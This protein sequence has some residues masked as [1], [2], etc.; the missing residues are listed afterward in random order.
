MSQG[1]K[2]LGCKEFL[3]LCG[4]TKNTL[5]WYEKKGLI[6]PK[7]VGENGYRYY[8]KEQFYE[9]DLIKSLKWVDKSLDDCKSYM[10]HRSEETYLPMLLE[11]QRTLEQ[12]IVAL[13]N[14][15]R[16]VDQT[17]QDYLSMK[18]RYSQ[19]PRFLTLPESYL[20]VEP[21]DDVTP[22]GYMMTLNRL[23]ETFHDCLP[24]YHA[25]PSM[26]NCSI[27]SHQDLLSENFHQLSYA[28]L[29]ISMQI[30]IAACRTIPKGT[31]AVCSHR[32]R[33]SSIHG[34]YAAM[35]KFIRANGM[36]P[37]GDALEN[38]YVNYLVASDPEQY[39]KEI[40][41]PVRPKQA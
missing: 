13:T 28:C 40:L 27:L 18:A 1:K 35:M 19:T 2:Y 37:A 6:S 30:P 22:R 9:I 7:A 23:F 16:I 39:I 5:I 31:F 14:Q 25:A 20:L 26:F 34:T 24:I 11:Q 36:E 41:I 3:T 15:K 32:G 17:I 4:I 10:D 8:S 33:I 38:D 12:K 21:I 29:K